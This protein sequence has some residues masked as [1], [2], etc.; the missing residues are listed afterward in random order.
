MLRVVLD[1]NVILSGLMSPKG[2]TGQIVQAWKDN[3]LTLLMCEAQLEEIK[4]VFNL[5]RNS[6]TIELVSRKNKPFL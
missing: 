3:R 2:T 6:K 4:R 1:S 5:P